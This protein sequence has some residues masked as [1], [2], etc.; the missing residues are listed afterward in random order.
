MHVI[1]VHKYTSNRLGSIRT[2]AYNKLFHAMVCLPHSTPRT[3][4]G[5]FPMV[6]LAHSTTGTPTGTFHNTS[7]RFGQVFNLNSVTIVYYGMPNF[8]RNRLS[9]TPK[10]SLQV[11]NKNQLCLSRCS[12]MKVSNHGTALFLQNILVK[13]YFRK[14]N[15]SWATP[16][17]FEFLDYISG[18]CT[19]RSL[20]YE[21]RK[22]VC[23]SIYMVQVRFNHCYPS[24]KYTSNRP[25]CILTSAYNKLFHAVVC[26]PYSTPR[27][28]TGTFH[29]TSH[30]YV[31]VFHLNSV[32]KS[33]IV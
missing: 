27:T 23:R 4:T 14:P 21:L 31:Q 30:R 20:G 13:V 16:Y 3:P 24:S 32:T 11:S 28:P 9:V 10:H 15:I 26:L 8:I 17:S 25:G 33:P 2:S 5:T 7:H 18:P 1:T 29:N 19:C 12:S 6:C 22:K